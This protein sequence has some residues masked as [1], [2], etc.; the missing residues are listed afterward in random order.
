MQLAIIAG[1]QAVEKIL[2]ENGGLELTTPF[3]ISGMDLPPE[4][5]KAAKNL[6]QRFSQSKV[7]TRKVPLSEWNLVPQEAQDLIPN[8]IPALLANFSLLGGV[9]E[10][11]NV[12]NDGEWPLYFSFLSPASYA[13][14]VFGK[15]RYCFMNEFVED[16][17]TLLSA[18]SNGNMWL[19]SISGGP[20]SP[21]YLFDLSGHEKILVS[22]RIDLLLEGMNVGSE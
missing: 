8:W 13:E 20:A 12:L 21:V 11:R 17:L 4:L 7:S 19:T 15:S 14:N 5:I 18:E 9:L 1:Q 3:V 6:E 22:E 2:R 10:Y 16:E